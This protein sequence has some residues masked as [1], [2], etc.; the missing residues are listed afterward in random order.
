MLSPFIRKDTLP[1]F[2]RLVKASD[3][4]MDDGN[5]DNYDEEA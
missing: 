1:C 4:F 5:I 3:I 2:L